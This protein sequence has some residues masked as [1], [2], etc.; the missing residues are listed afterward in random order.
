MLGA[1]VD[2]IYHGPEAFDGYGECDDRGNAYGCEGER[3]IQHSTDEEVVIR[4]RSS[5]SKGTENKIVETCSAR[6][7]DANRQKQAEDGN[8]DKNVD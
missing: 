2:E 6:E 7:G 4:S 8:S 1:F 3:L 5:T